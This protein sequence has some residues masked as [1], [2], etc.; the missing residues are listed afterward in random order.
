[1][2]NIRT[3]LTPQTRGTL[4]T[5]AAALVTALVVFGFIAST[6][7]PAIVGLLV[8]IITLVYAIIHSESTIRT[9][10]YGVCA[11]TAGLFIGL[12]TLTDVQ[13][14]SLLAVVAP[15]LGITLAAAKTPTGQREV[16]VDTWVS[17][18]V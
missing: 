9:A 18:S 2:T 13:S 15:V 10:I 6:L 1:M 11:A 12:G 8:A 4:Y 3:W 17:H 5:V 16:E 7:A 14:E